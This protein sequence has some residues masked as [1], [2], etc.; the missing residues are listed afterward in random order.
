MMWEIKLTILNN[1]DRDDSF[2]RKSE[3]PLMLSI[4]IF[5]LLHIISRITLHPAEAT[6]IQ[7]RPANIAVSGNSWNK[8]YGQ[9]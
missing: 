6:P 2:R 3:R 4:G 9:W 8:Q 1:I 5:I 7:N